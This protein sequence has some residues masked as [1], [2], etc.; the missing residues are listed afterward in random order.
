MDG[1]KICSKGELKMAFEIRSMISQDWP[2]VSRIYRIGIEAGN[3][4]FLQQCPSYEE[5]DSW[6][7]PEYRLVAAD[8][9][10]MA[11]WSALQLT[12]SK[13]A[14][15]GLLELSIYMD[16]AYRNQGVGTMLLQKMIE[17]SQQHGVWG[18]QSCIMANNEAS[19]ALHK[20]CGFRMIGR[21]EKS[22]KDRYG[23]WQDTI[24]ME[25]RS[26]L[27]EYQ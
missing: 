19:L 6:Y 15:R 13:P 23:V 2:E 11:G 22:A 25:K 21:R 7:L 10:K 18:L 3:A 5:W 14:Y 24:L 16:P 8:G 17:Y 26:Q 27:P 1:W 20:K 12:S 9:D 4:T